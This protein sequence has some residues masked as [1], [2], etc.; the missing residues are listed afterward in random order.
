VVTELLGPD[1]LVHSASIFSKHTGDG[2]YVAWHQD[3]HYWRLSEPRLVSAWIALSASTPE[4]G[5]MRV[6]RGTHRDHLAH[7]EQP[8]SGNMLASGLRVDADV[9]PD[10]VVDICL[11]PGQM[12]LH[13]ERIV[14]GSELNRAADKRIGF[15]VRYVATDVSQALAHHAV[16]LARGRDEHGHYEHLPE[17]PGT[18]LGESLARQAAFADAIRRRRLGVHPEAGPRA[19]AAVASDAHRH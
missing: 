7:R 17:P 15:A 1:V 3:G 16:I 19:E 5:C 8:G 13:H 12:S 6:V 11:E 18:D 14:H 9:D 4:S 10:K 2:L